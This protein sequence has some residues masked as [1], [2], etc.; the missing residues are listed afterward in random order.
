MDEL[1]VQRCELPWMRT[2]SCWPTSKQGVSTGGG[3]DDMPT[4]SVSL[5]V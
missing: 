5:N 1:E 4:E 3:G 2:R